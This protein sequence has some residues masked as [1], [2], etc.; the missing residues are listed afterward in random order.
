MSGSITIQSY[1][2]LDAT[3]ETDFIQAG[4]RWVKFKYYQAIPFD[5]LTADSQSEIAAVP[6][7][8]Y[9][10]EQSYMQNAGAAIVTKVK[11]ILSTP[12][13]LDGEPITLKV[14]SIYDVVR[15][16]GN[17]YILNIAGNQVA[18]PALNVRPLEPHEAIPN[19]TD[20]LLAG[21]D[22]KVDFLLDS[23][24]L[25][26]KIV[27]LVAEGIAQQAK[28]QVGDLITMLDGRPLSSPRQFRADVSADGEKTL[29]VRRGSQLY[30]IAIG[31]SVGPNTPQPPQRAKWPDFGVGGQ[32]D[33]KNEFVVGWVYGKNTVARLV[34]LER[35]DKILAVN[36]VRID[37]QSDL[38]A[39]LSQ[40]GEE[41][42]VVA[43]RKGQSNVTELRLALDQI[44]MDQD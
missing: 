12:V 25:Q 6:R 27:E 32:L 42:T 9:E 20:D 26:V 40:A 21:L 11:I 31:G 5:R 30:K 24:S 29:T 7:L 19:S 34:G 37:R 17:T 4:R 10:L 1:S 28:M 2:P 44:P 15:R 23:Q 13:Q 22:A 39:A 36:S 18:V 8:R 14:G 41:I 38:D 35:D 3:Y 33:D 43:I 16:D